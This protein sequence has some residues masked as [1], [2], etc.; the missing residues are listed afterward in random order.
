MVDF[1]YLQHGSQPGPFRTERVS[2]RLRGWPHVGIY[3]VFFEGLWRA[4]HVQVR[5]TF[6]VYQG[7]RITIQ[8]DGV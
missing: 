1:G 4:V 6:I 5:R 7:A 8:I 3:E 2:V